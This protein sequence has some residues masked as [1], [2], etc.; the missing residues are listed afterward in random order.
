[1]KYSG[2]CDNL[3]P[4]FSSKFRFGEGHVPRVKYSGYCD[5]LIPS[6]SKFRFGEGHVPRVKYL[7]Y[8]DNLIPSFSSKFR[9]TDRAKDA[10]ASAAEAILG[11]T[12]SVVT[13]ALRHASLPETMG[14]WL[15]A[16][17]RVPC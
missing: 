3:I 9:E 8:Y 6:F 7:G 17:R 13:G 2:Y 11:G 4:S 5:N 15:L 12:V 14:T 10:S 1:M 16:M